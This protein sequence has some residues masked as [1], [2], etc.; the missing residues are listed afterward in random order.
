M[1]S[2]GPFRFVAEAVTYLAVST[3]LEPVGPMPG[4]DPATPVATPQG[5]RRVDSLKRGDLVLS[6]T[7]GSLPVLHVLH[8]E[9]PALGIFRPVTLRAPFFGLQ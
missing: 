5:Y 1:I 3:A 8:R 9:V 6:E 4:L 7:G 2:P